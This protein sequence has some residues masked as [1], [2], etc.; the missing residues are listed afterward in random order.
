MNPMHFA[1]EMMLGGKFY[2]E[3]MLCPEVEGGGQATIARILTRNYPNV[4]LDKRADRLRGSFNVFGWSTNYNRKRWAIGTLQRT[5][6]DGSLTMH[7]RKTYN[8]LRNYVEDDSG[9]WGNADREMHD[10]AVMALA[11]GIVASEQEGPFTADPPNRSP[12]HDLYAQEF[13]TA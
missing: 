12:I 5:I 13:D 9:Y 6:I 10:D 8:Q 7:D 1:D 4:W 2:N 3:C 11:I